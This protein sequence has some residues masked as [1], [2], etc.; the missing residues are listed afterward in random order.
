MSRIDPKVICQDLA[1][2]PKI[3]HASQK[4]KPSEERQKAAIEE[5]RELVRAG[6]IRVLFY[7]LASQRCHGKKG[8]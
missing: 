6:F 5:T 2:D 3:K 4:R 8:I 7:H 1:I